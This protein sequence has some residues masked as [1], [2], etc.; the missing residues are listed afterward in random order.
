MFCGGATRDLSQKLPS[1]DPASACANVEDRARIFQR[2]NDAA[3][4]LICR[5]HSRPNSWAI[6][7]NTAA[8]ACDLPDVDKT[9]R[10]QRS[11]LFEGGLNIPQRWRR[12]AQSIL[13]VVGICN[14]NTRGH[15]RP[16]ISAAAIIPISRA[17]H[18]R[19]HGNEG[20][21]EGVSRLRE[22]RGMPAL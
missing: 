11:G 3:F 9:R 20:A 8:P 16:A 21:G 10:S 1:H 2:T 5:L 19:G 17:E 22:R 6:K 14:R 15:R 12:R 4:D 18:T 7:S 13:E